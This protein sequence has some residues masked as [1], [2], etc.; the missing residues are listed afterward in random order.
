MPAKGNKSAID[1][2]I[3]DQVRAKRLAANLS[4]L[5]LAF[6]LGVSLGFIGHIESPRYTAKYNIEHINKLAE[7][8][9]CSV[10]D[11]FPDRSLKS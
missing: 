5:D 8:F 6:A 11:F 2:Y 4:Q 10:K 7:I 3:I 1:L 9:D